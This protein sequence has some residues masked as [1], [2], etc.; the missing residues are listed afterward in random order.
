MKNTYLLFY[1]ESL[2]R[3]SSKRRH[4]NVQ[5]GGVPPLLPCTT[6]FLSDWTSSSC[7]SSTLYSMIHERNE[8]LKCPKIWHIFKTPITLKKLKNISHLCSAQSFQEILIPKSVLCN[9]FL[10]FV[11]FNA[12][13]MWQ[14][15]TYLFQNLKGK[16]EE[17]ISKGSLSHCFSTIYQSGSS[18]VC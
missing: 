6:I 15:N 12:S 7:P 13:L 9:A 3:T 8:K 18:F 4:P 11:S 5:R 17:F 10:H 2:A 1:F 16:R 14:I